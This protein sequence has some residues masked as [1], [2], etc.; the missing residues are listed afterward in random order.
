MKASY[1]RIFQQNSSYIS[2]SL[3]NLLYML[4]GIVAFARATLEYI[5]SRLKDIIIDLSYSQD[6]KT[7]SVALV[8][9]RH[10]EGVARLMLRHVKRQDLRCSLNF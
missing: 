6:S 10:R 7:V 3:T 5:S 8:W 1:S 2:S 9:L 4:L